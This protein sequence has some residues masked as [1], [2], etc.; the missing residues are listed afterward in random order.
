[1]A[2]LAY[3]SPSIDIRL[4]DNDRQDHHR[5]CGEVLDAHLRFAIA[6]SNGASCASVSSQQSCDR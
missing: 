2:L 5:K 3:A 6:R 4:A 1:M